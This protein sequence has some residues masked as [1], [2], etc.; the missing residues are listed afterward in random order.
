[1]KIKRRRD[2]EKTSPMAEG[3]EGSG[4]NHQVVGRENDGEDSDRGK[5]RSIEK[6]AEAEE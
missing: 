4:G 3:P 2:G 1:M 6:V 5:K